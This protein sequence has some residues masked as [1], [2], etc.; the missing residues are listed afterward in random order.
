MA[1]LVRAVPLFQ[2]SPHPAFP[3]ACS[4]PRVLRVSCRPGARP[5]ERGDRGHPRP[6]AD[7]AVG[8]LRLRG[9]PL[10]Q[11]QPHGAVPVRVQP[12]AVRGRGAHPDLVP[13][14]PAGPAS[15]HDHPAAAAAVQ[16]RRPHGER[17][18]GGA[19]GG[20]R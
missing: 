5:P 20:G 1:E 18:A 2:W 12:A 7:P 9:H 13:L 8:A 15:L 4:E 6:A 14:H 19:D 11:L 10:P 17:G 16:P 3:V